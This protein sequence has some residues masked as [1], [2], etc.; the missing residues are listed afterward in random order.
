LR[1]DLEA[2]RADVEGEHDQIEEWEFRDGRI[3][4]SVGSYEDES[5]PDSGHGWLCR[6]TDVGALASAGFSRV[7]KAQ[8]L[9]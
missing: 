7:R 6:L 2:F 3:F 4:A 5:N 8:L 1:A 9:P